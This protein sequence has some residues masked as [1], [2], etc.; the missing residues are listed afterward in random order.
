MEGVPT[1]LIR[2]NVNGKAYQIRFDS[3]IEAAGFLKRNGY[4]YVMTVDGV[5]L[6]NY[7]EARITE[8]FLFPPGEK[9]Y[10]MKVY[11]DRAAVYPEYSGSSLYILESNAKIH[12]EQ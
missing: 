4:L 2:N 11:G 6:V 1:V 9:S 7:P 3:G 5:F 8:R 12:S 10:R